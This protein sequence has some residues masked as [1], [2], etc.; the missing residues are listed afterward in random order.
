M[1]RRKTLAPKMYPH[2][3]SGQWCVTLATTS[4]RR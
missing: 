1:G 3:A 4:D 2:I